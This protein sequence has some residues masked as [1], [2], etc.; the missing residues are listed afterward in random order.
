M[1]YQN[2]TLKVI[3]PKKFF[4]LVKSFDTKGFNYCIELGN[5]NTIK[6]IGSKTDSS[7]QLINAYELSDL[8]I[9]KNQSF[10][11]QKLVFSIGFDENTTGILDYMIKDSKEC[12]I[13]L[14]FIKDKLF[15]SGGELYYQELDMRYP[16]SV[17]ANSSENL[18]PIY[19]RLDLLP[20]KK[21]KVLLELSIPSYILKKNL[22]NPQNDLWLYLLNKQNGQTVVFSDEVYNLQIVDEFT[23]REKEF[24]VLINS[25]HLKY[26]D[27]HEYRIQV[28]SKYILFSSTVKES[29]I[30]IIVSEYLEETSHE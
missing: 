26:L 13:T 1:Q 19:V 14:Q 24:A 25:Q 30:Y 15:A 28:Y 6:F 12:E 16:F 29:K 7:I 27:K 2:F 3:N 17:K 23:T 22:N 10:E 21:Q 20:T 4:G 11:F 9:I 18:Q 8:I 5:D